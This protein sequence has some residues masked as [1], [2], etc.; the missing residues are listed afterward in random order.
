MKATRLILI[1]A[2]VAAIAV[3]AAGST[4]S[5]SA[6]PSKDIVDTA[7]GGGKF[8]TLTSLLT[9]AG[10]VGTLRG[11]GPYTVFAPTDAAFRRV[12]KSTLRALAKDKARLRSV[13]LYHVAT[14]ELTAAKLVKRHSLKTLNGRSVRIR[15]R[16][17]NVTVGRARV[18]RPDVAASNGVI[19][20]INRVLIPQG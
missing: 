6:G 19:H 11:A 14:G 18:I 1:L 12:P 15:V 16:G 17:S 5:P 13:L 20:V 8:K 2:A 7:V 4:A 3:P 9:R 10:L